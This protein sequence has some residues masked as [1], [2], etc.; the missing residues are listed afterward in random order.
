[1]ARTKK[2]KS[3]GRA[4]IPH[5]DGLHFIPLGG[6]EQF[7]VNLNLYMCDG[8]WL[9]A[10]CGI[11]FADEGHPGVDI[12][13]PDPA[14]IE[15]APERLDALVVTHA[16][17]DH[18][19]A[20]AYL[21]ERLGR[22]AVYCTAFTGQVLANKFRDQDIRGAQVNVVGERARVTVGP[23][24]V[25][26]V[27]MAHSIPDTVGLVI[28]TKYGRVV[29][30][31]D[32]NLDPTPVAGFVTD[33]EMLKKAG[34]EGVL[35]YVGDSTNAQVQGSTGSEAGVYDGLLAEFRK[36]EGRIAVTSFS[37]NIGRVINVARAAK[38]VGRRVCVV[39]RSLHNMI[40]AAHTLGM[41]AGVDDFIS[42]E[43]LESTPRDKVVLIVTGSQGEARAALS[44]IA[45]GDFSGVRLE[46]GDTVV[47][48][49]RM[50]PGNERA[51]LDVQ[52]VLIASGIRIV[53]PNEA[54]GAIHVSGHPRRDDVRQ[55]YDWVRPEIVVPVHG[56]YA[57]VSA[58]AGLARDHGIKHVIQPHNGAVI[59]L[60]PGEPGIV[61]TVGVGLLAVE[62]GRIIDAG[63]AAIAERRK[64]AAEGVVHV[65][66]VLS[67]DGDI[68]G[69]PVVDT[70]GLLDD[71]LGADADLLDDL[72]DAALGALEGMKARDR[73][74]DERVEA[75]LAR[76][77][78]K[79]F[80]R[81]LKVKP[82]VIVHVLRV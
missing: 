25:Q 66:T 34:D 5:A 53:T 62:R 19:G 27:P 41:M 4:D 10:D 50:I 63:H 59:R 72:F 46:A 48:S 45:R 69:D 80:W 52:N 67:A 76:A 82:Q 65:S 29:H 8:R 28:E 6:S 24:T 64:A 49:S 33:G 44:R 3:A 23:F 35:A 7:G 31:G 14:F 75:A 73:R 57:Q 71:T 37:S 20:V 74:D 61:D 2:K 16:H 77:A 60:A 15:R 38:A 81:A 55:M 17:E 22:P 42:E 11:G 79:L 21:Y 56:E 47:Y 12:L 26:C 9:L 30:S 13:L 36:C 32:W 40:A 18:V 54:Q 1:M 51:I 58:Q 70:I 68:A 43:E 39:G 78:R